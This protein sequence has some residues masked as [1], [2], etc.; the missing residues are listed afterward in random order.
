MNCTAAEKNCGRETYLFGLV[1]GEPAFQVLHVQSGVKAAMSKLTQ[2]LRCIV[3][4]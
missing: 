4:G 1:V 2:W 3:C